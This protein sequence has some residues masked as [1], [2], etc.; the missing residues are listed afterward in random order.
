VGA[1]LARL[2]LF[3]RHPIPR[4]ELYE[5][6]WPEEDLDDVRPRF[7]QALATLRRQLEPHGTPSGSVLAADRQTVW[8]LPSA[9]TCDVTEFLKAVSAGDV[10]RAKEIYT[11]ELLPGWYD[12]WI[13]DERVRLQAVFETLQGGKNHA[14][15]VSGGKDPAVHVRSLPDYLTDFVGRQRELQQLATVLSSHRLVTVVGI[16]G[17]GKTRLAVEAARSSLVETDR[18]LFVDLVECADPALIGRYIAAA[19]RAVPTADDPL[20]CWLDAVGDERLLLIL[21]NWEHLKG[22]A[23]AAVLQ[24]L[25]SSPDIRILV[26]SRVHCGVDGE[27]VF[28]LTPMRL[29]EGQE[30]LADA[31]SLFANRAALVRPGFRINPQNLGAVEALVRKLDGLPLAIELAAARSRAYSLSD[32]LQELNRGLRLLA[33]PASRDGERG[34]RHDSIRATMEWSVRTLSEQQRLFFLKLAVFRGGWTSSAAVQV[35]GAENAAE[36]LE[37]LAGRSLIQA[38]ELPDGA[39]RFRMLETVSAFAMEQCPPEHLR[40]AAVAH[41][42]WA[43][44]LAEN[45]HGG[46]QAEIVYEGENIIAAMRTALS[47]GLSNL[48]LRLAIAVDDAWIAIAGPSQTTDLLTAAAETD[49][50]ILLRVETLARLSQ[51]RL[52]LSDRASAVRVARRAAEV[53]AGSP[54]AEC[55]AAMAEI[56]AGMVNEPAMNKTAEAAMRDVVSSADRL[57]V[58]LVS[59]WGRRLLGI[60]A[61]R[62]GRF[63]EADQQLREAFRLAQTA[64][65]RAEQVLVLDS[66]GNNAVCRGEND[67]ALDIYREAQTLARETSNAVYQAKVLQN[68]ATIYARQQ[69]WTEALASGIEC[70]HRNRQLGSTLMLAYTF[71]N[72]AE[73]MLHLGFPAEAAEIQSFSEQYWVSHYDPLNEEELAYLRDIRTAVEERIG[74]RRTQHHWDRGA[75]C[76][77][78]QAMETVEGVGSTVWRERQ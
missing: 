35:L 16:G 8:L 31:L 53:A 42:E 14:G 77:L 69:Q 63:D 67:L 55:I 36:R 3:P 30:G 52:Q 66:L 59:Q 33:R 20:K 12:D 48:A 15:G 5:L 54:A 24:R 45:A 75:R 34:S 25:L 41:A 9:F 7:R 62:Q 51:M 4:E 11:G 60:L 40:E 71:W 27:A 78:A 50:D 2:A 13:L 56:R 61:T 10:A 49:G 72:I 57:Q 19:D 26:T 73:P 1:L 32:L 38:A 64:G 74:S 70:L 21:D 65:N 37:D 39:L 28:E 68:L 6:L 43:C 29:D 22:D 17:I 46:D 47:H 44:K 18:V 58:S 76:T 23:A